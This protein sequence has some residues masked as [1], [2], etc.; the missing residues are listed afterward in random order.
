MQYQF[1]K[2]LK[3]CYTCMNNYLTLFNK[4]H[5]YKKFRPKLQTKLKILKNYYHFLAQFSMSD[6]TRTCTSEPH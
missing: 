1:L 5:V 2:K 4:K 6:V 3:E